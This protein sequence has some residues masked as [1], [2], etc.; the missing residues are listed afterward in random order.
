[1]SNVKTVS[2]A[3]QILIK[4]NK[5]TSQNS[6]VQDYILDFQRDIYSVCIIYF[7][8]RRNIPL[9]NHLWVVHYI[10]FN[11]MMNKRVLFIYDHKA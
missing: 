3:E 4:V 6:E 11:E 10:I 2:D 8:S 7:F 9:G 5:L 1:M